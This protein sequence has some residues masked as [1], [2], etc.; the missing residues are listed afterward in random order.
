[1]PATVQVRAVLFPYPRCRST[2]P[3]RWKCGA[4]RSTADDAE[5]GPERE[6]I[7]LAAED[8]D[9]AATSGC[10]GRSFDDRDG[11]AVRAYG[12]CAR[13]NPSMPTRFRRTFWLQSGSS[14]SISDHLRHMYPTPRSCGEREAMVGTM[15]TGSARTACRLRRRDHPE[16]GWAD[17]NVKNL[18]ARGVRGLGGGW[19][20]ICLVC[21]GLG[22][23]FSLALGRSSFH[24]PVGRERI[25]DP[26]RP[27]HTRKRPGRCQRFATQAG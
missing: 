7:C 2:R 23:S 22:S 20:F 11:A 26:P 19:G 8:R 13:R 14:V 27:P 6:G 15:L 16:L 4:Y 25:R 21:I 10:R 17:I 1:V 5:C 24:S 9:A 12:G 18:V 3:R